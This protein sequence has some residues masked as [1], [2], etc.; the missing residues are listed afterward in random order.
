MAAA[1]VATG[2]YGRCGTSMT[3]A[4]IGT[5]TR[6]DPNGQMPAMA[7][8]SV[9]LPAP[10]G[11]VTSTRSPASSTRCSAST[12]GSPLGRRTARWSIATALAPS[13]GTTSIT[14]G[15][16]AACAAGLDRL[17]E[18]GQPRH[19]RLIFGDRPVGGDE[20]GQRVLHAVEGRRGLHQAAELHRA[21]EIGRAHHHIGKDHRGL[22]IAR[23]EEREL[24]LPLHDG[25]PV[26][27]HAAEAVEVALAFGRFAVQR[28]DLLGIF[29]RAHQI[30]TKIGL[31][32]L[33][34][35]IERDQRPADQMRERRCRSPHRS[36]PPRPDSRGIVSAEQCSGACFR[37]IPQDDDE[38]ARASRQR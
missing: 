8:N 38:R 6:P 26:V 15:V 21:G 9:D 29:A 19:H 13:R 4:S 25:D 1:S 27:D 32:A 31:E 37:Q 35:E 33:L 18:P 12:S 11:P 23:G 2:K 34:P 28:G 17:L 16:S 22:R 24:L 36:A 7:R 3:L 10:E 14:G 30:E 20:I 5:V